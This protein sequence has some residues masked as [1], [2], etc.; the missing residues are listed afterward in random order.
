MVSWIFVVR[1]GAL[2]KL[3]ESEF[4]AEVLSAYHAMNHDYRAKMRDLRAE[5]YGVGFGARRPS[6]KE[7]RA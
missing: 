3:D 2:A 1:D 6:D 4:V 7:N 5:H